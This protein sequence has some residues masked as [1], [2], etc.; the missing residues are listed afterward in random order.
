MF[1]LTGL[2]LPNEELKECEDVYE[3]A[4][5]LLG[6]WKRVDYSFSSYFYARFWST[7]LRFTKGKSNQIE[8]LKKHLN[9]FLKH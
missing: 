7:A 4:E 8:E 5:I 6:F 3:R 2:E 1:Y 9:F